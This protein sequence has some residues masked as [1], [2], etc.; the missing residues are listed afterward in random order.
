M[1]L[2]QFNTTNVLKLLKN[3]HNYVIDCSKC[4]FL[5]LIHISRIKMYSDQCNKFLFISKQ[6]NVFVTDGIAQRPRINKYLSY[7]IFK[8]R[9]VK[10]YSKRFE[11]KNT[12]KT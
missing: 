7:I 9:E 1:L 12:Y 5:K 11:I 8:I 3:S 10:W 6:F 2:L 4:Y